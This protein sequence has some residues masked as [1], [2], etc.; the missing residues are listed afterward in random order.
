MCILKMSAGALPVR[1]IGQCPCVVAGILI[2]GV[3][4]HPLRIGTNLLNVTVW[5]VFLWLHSL[6]LADKSHP[7]QP[8]Q[9]FLFLVASDFTTLYITA[10]MVRAMMSMTMVS[11]FMV[12]WMNVLIS[13]I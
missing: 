5:V 2:G 1:R 12:M 6:F 13:V 8:P 9:L 11:W 10:P 3:P 4:G 7:V